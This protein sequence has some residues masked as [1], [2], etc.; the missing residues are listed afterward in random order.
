MPV[1]PDWHGYRVL[2][3]ETEVRA[4][5]GQQQASPE[6]CGGTA[7]ARDSNSRAPGCVVASEVPQGAQ[8]RAHS[9]EV[10][11]A[12]R[13][14]VNREDQ[15][16]VLVGEPCHDLADDPRTPGV[17]PNGYF[18]GTEIRRAPVISGAENVR[19]A[20]CAGEGDL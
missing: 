11:Q 4:L 8:H 3:P 12:A 17:K 1:G 13:P 6:H 15:V 14:A 20:R 5:D 2:T 16:R 7:D 9:P 19:R 18:F 10:H